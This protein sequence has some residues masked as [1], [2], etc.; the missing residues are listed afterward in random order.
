MT[1]QERLQL[2]LELKTD[3]QD[4]RNVPTRPYPSFSSW[5]TTRLGLISVHLRNVRL[6]LMSVHLRN[7]RPSSRKIGNS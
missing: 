6:G 1:R 2:L 3:P 7:V 4:S 5:K